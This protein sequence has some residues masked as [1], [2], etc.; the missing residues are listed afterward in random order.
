MCIW[1]VILK[2]MWLALLEKNEKC[3]L[4]SKTK[5]FHS[6]A[7]IGALLFLYIRIS[8]RIHVSDWF[9]ESAFLIPFIKWTHHFSLTW[10]EYLLKGLKSLHDI[11]SSYKISWKFVSVFASHWNF[12]L[13]LYNPAKNLILKK[14]FLVHVFWT[15]IAFKLSL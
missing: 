11:S 13:S 6:V 15:V 14:A 10:M 4:C 1:G 9:A 5:G 8:K 7:C 12:E 2:Y 3:Q